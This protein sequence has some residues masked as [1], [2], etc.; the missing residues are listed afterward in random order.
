M[1]AAHSIQAT[2]TDTLWVSMKNLNNSDDKRKIQDLGWGKRWLA[3]MPEI[4]RNN[5]KSAEF[6]WKQVFNVVVWDVLDNPI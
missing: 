5:G 2:L 4:L 3:H 1:T 6:F